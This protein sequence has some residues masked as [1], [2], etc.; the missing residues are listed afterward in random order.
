MSSIYNM[1]N[2][3]FEK[4]ILFSYGGVFKYI[5]KEKETIDGV[6]CLRHYSQ[7][8]FGAVLYAV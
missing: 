5:L 7:N 2:F 8:L 1:I 3:G 6:V 4:A